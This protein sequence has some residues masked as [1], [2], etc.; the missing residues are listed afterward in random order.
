METGFIEG[1]RLCVVLY[2]PL[3]TQHISGHYGSDVLI[4]LTGCH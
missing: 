3:A 2:L 1:R 4:G